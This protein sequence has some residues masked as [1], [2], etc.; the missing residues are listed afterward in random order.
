MWDYVVVEGGVEYVCEVVDC[1]RAK[2]LEMS[3]VD[4]VRAYGVVIFGSF[5]CC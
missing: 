1:E 2:V 3:D 4:V 5:D